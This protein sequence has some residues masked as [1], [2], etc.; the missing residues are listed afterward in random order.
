MRLAGAGWP[1]QEQRIGLGPSPL[2]SNRL[3]HLAHGGC[4]RAVF[5][6]R[7]PAGKRVHSS[8]ILGPTGGQMPCYSIGKPAASQAQSLMRKGVQNKEIGRTGRAVAEAVIPDLGGAVFATTAPPEHRLHQKAASSSASSKLAA[9]ILSG[10][11]K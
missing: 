2:N 7:N 9:T 4:R 5:R 3:D 6:R 10:S 11:S 8:T 1:V